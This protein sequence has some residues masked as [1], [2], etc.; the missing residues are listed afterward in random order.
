[1]SGGFKHDL[2]KLTPCCWSGLGC[3]WLDTVT[4]VTW[5]SGQGWP[6]HISRVD[7]ALSCICVGYSTEL[8]QT[9]TYSPSK[10]HWSSNSQALRPCFCNEINLCTILPAD[11]NVWEGELCQMAAGPKNGQHCTKRQALKPQVMLAHRG[12]E[13]PPVLQN[14]GVW[15]QFNCK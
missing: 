10:L 13:I 1:M 8:F 11:F 4:F 9:V 5:S 7:G 2:G 3:V 6:L 12:G 15:C 14:E